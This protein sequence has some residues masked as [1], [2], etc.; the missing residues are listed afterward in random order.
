MTYIPSLNSKI[1]ANNS[2]KTLLVSGANTFTGTSTNVAGFAGIHLFISTNKPSAVLGLKVEFSPDNSTWY[3]Y[4]QQSIQPN[5]SQKVIK[6][7]VHGVYFKLTYTNGTEDQTGTSQITTY[8]I[9]TSGS[10]EVTVLQQKKNVDS[11]AKLKVVNPFTLLDLRFFTTGTSPN[12]TDENALLSVI[13]TDNITDFTHSYANASMTIAKSGTGATG[14]FISQSRRYVAYQPGKT[15]LINATGIINNGS[16]SSG[17]T[18]NIGYYDDND[19]VFFQYNNGI[20]VVMRKN[21][22]VDVPIPSSSWNIDP[23][24]GT[25]PSGI[26]LEFTKEQFFIIEFA[27][28]GV[29]SIR[30]GFLFNDDVY[31]CHVVLNSNALTSPYM[32]NPNLPVRYELI[33]AAAGDEGSMVQGCATIISEGGYNPIGRI[34]SA[35]NTASVAINNSTEIPMVAISGN[36]DYYHQIISPNSISFACISQSDAILIRVRLYLAGVSTGLTPT[37]TDVNADHSVM[38]QATSFTGTVTTTDSIV[39][40]QS[41]AY[42]HSNFNANNITNTFTQLSSN[43]ANTSDILLVTA[44]SVSGNSATGLAS[45]TWEEIY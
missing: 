9:P 37:W 38:Q 41:Y 12:A 31:F 29:G 5:D 8:L 4:L 45:V 30:F 7:D 18:T 40:N 26:T 20:H 25:G 28:L 21:G 19:G 27:W 22:V 39:L 3:T 13:E 11:Y 6:I 44:I 33:G 43:I 1:D 16:N 15:M 14:Y 36:S 23:M 10:N 2:Y 17:I 35:G 32:D 42:S 34:F 24:D